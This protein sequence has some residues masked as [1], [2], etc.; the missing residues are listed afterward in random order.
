[1]IFEPKFYINYIHST[2]ILFKFN[3]YPLAPIP[4]IRI[5]SQLSPNW[6]PFGTYLQGALLSRLELCR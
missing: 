5:G 6:L 1:M 3:I 4:Y 2:N